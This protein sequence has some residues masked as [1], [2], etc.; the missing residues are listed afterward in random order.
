MLRDA[1]TG[2]LTFERSVATRSV[3]GA[4]RIT[5]AACVALR[6]WRSTS[7]SDTWG[8]TRRKDHTNA[9]AVIS[10][11]LQSKLLVW[12]SLLWQA[13]SVIFF[14]G[15]HLQHLRFLACWLIC[16]V[17]NFSVEFARTC[18]EKN[19]WNVLTNGQQTM[20]KINKLFWHL[21]S[22]SGKRRKADNNRK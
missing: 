3:I 22:S 14:E 5:S 7:W 15:S 6:V 9:P 20:R 1:D 10:R 12:T 13:L 8:H 11:R 17:L 18:E 21:V 19:L 2:H 4:R 16:E